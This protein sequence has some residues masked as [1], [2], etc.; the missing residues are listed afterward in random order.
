M[1][2]AGT[3]WTDE[4]KAQLKELA[5]K[6]PSPYIS[7]IL[8]RGVAGVQKQIKKLGYQ[9]FSQHRPAAPQVPKKVPYQRVRIVGTV[10]WCKSC[11]A[12]V[13]NFSDHYE[14]MPKCRKIA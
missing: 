2:E 1:A 9:P 5:G 11:G 7:K 13:S 8:R 4:E 14:R 3:P 6:H 10:E 12:P